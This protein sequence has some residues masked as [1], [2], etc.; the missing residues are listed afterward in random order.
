MKIKRLL[1]T[2][3]F[4]M[5]QTAF[6]LNDKPEAFPS[7][8]AIQSVGVNH[9]IYHPNEGWEVRGPKNR[10]DTKEKW[11]FTIAFGD[12]LKDKDALATAK[13]FMAALDPTYGD[14]ISLGDKWGCYYVATVDGERGIGCAMTHSE[15]NLTLDISRF[16]K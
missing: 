11:Q 15:P 8:A 5:A 14:P 10:Y 13:E 16:Y 3:P 12:T 2:L 7:L 1:I 4:I 9:A 6:A